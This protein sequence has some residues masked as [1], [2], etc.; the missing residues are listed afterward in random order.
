MIA[1][2]ISPAAVGEIATRGPVS[3]ADS[4]SGA[5]QARKAIAEVT[6]KSFARSMDVSSK[7]R[8]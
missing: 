5:P 2:G 8:R 3:M 7:G 4:L 6:V 1:G